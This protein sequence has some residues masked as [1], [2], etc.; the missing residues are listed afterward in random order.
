MDEPVER[1]AELSQLAEVVRNAQI[2][3]GQVCVIE[4]P[5]GIGKSR[6]LKACAELADAAHVRVARVLCSELT[7]DYPFG[8]IHILFGPI[9]MRADSASRARALQGP[10]SLS[11]PVFGSGT[12]TDEFAVL[13]GLYWL[14]VNLAEQGPLVL[15]VDDLPWADPLSQRFFAYLAER[16]DDLPIALIATIRSGDPGAASPWVTSVSSSATTAAIQPAALSWHAVE[17]LLASNLPQ[18]TVDKE[19]VDGVVR[20][21]GGNPFYVVALTD[22]I[23]ADEK[24]MLSTPEQVRWHI[25]R[26]LT[27]FGSSEV[28]FANASA[29]LGNEASLRAVAQ[30]AALADDQ[31]VTAAE[32]LAAGHILQSSDPVVFT[33]S[34]VRDAI[35]GS[36]DIENRLAL[37][38]KAAHVMAAA[39][40]EPEVVAEH[41]LLSSKTQDRWARDALHA[42]GSAAARKGAPA[43]ALRY[44]RRAV[45]ATD[46]DQIPSSLLIEVGLAEAASG[47]VASLQHF[48]R[49]LTMVTEPAEQADALFSLGAT[50][51]RFGRYPEARSAFRRGTE[52]FGSSDQRLRFESALWSTNAHLSPT[53][54]VPA[55]VAELAE[56]SGVREIWAVKALHESLTQPPARAAADLA[57]RA[58]DGGALLSARGSQCV[59]VHVATLAL[60]QCNRLV[61]ANESADAVVRHAVDHG[62]QLEYAEA[63][64]TRALILHARGRIDDA[65]AD[66][67][68]ALERLEPR[69]NIHAHTA[70]AVLVHCLID[71]GEWDHAALLAGSA[72]LDLLETPFVKAYCWIAKGRLHLSRGETKAASHVV[73]KLRTLLRP[74]ND[75]DLNP[76]LLPWRS[77]AAITAHRSGDGPACIRYF[78]EEIELAKSFDVPIALGT[79]LRRRADTEPVAQAL[80][81]Y[82]L[83]IEALDES[84]ALLQLARAHVGVG[85]CLTRRNDL[86]AARRHLATALD[87][88]HR[89]G[90]AALMTE[91]RYELTTAGGRPRRSALSGKESLTPTEARIARLAAQGMPSRDIAEQ[92]FVSRNT[93]TWHLRNVYRKLNVESR[94]QLSARWDAAG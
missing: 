92:L 83:A 84:D 73:D 58:L 70:T 19:L 33:H 22:A 89:C 3:N 68:A 9:L 47:E 50:L 77:M 39:A 66:A 16:V 62:L 60:M 18:G 63:S 88:A 56:K 85:R 54:G 82:Q 53:E 71:R 49:A 55:D 10:A 79:A 7:R 72:D 30:L 45:D 8:V 80:K 93:V 36:L 69:G 38:A 31:G 87:L 59:A 34:I 42:A 57:A 25:T 14:T 24:P 2:G 46:A 32:N 51:Y 13:H 23:R 41:V 76:T 17:A 81:T 12:A 11:E 78:E 48:E 86:V 52:L 44:L 35:Y 29:V 74:L 28:A 37:H 1:A 20:R 67:Q 75:G 40:A 61:E 15:L 6:L 90:A 5:S 4:G 27:R 64:W 26:R 91:I 21:T 65:A 94:E 43:A